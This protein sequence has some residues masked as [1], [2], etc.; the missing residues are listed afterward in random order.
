M[1]WVRKL[2]KALAW[3]V[4]GVVALVLVTYGVV[5]LVNLH[6][7]PPS[8]TALRF[9][10]EFR[11]RPLVADDENAFVYA[12]GFYVKPGAD[13][14]AAGIERIAWM[15]K[16]SRDSLLDLMA[17]PPDYDYRAARSPAVQKISEACRD[18]GRDCLAAFQDEG[19]TL[20]EWSTAEQWLLERY[21]AL[22]LRPGWRESAPFEP[23]TRMQRPCRTCSRRTRASGAIRSSSPTW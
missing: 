9:A 8:E 5:L 19:P 21:L 1:S 15:R 22:I 23:A 7:R 13:P 4:G 10:A 6:D 17:H 18:V 16:A 3:L 12:T 11:D 2:S 20:K 14:Q